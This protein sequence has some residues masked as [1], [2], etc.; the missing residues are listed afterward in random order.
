MSD[1][2]ASKVKKES[3][4]AAVLS[5]GTTLTKQNR[6]IVELDPRMKVRSNKDAQDAD[7]DN[8]SQ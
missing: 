5:G 2:K 7:D 1:D 6:D 3:D 4:A 8:K